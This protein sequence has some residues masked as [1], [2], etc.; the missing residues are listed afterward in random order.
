MG[1]LDRVGRRIAARSGVCHFLRLC[2]YR[3]PVGFANP[4]LTRLMKANLISRVR[5]ICDTYQSGLEDE[6]VIVERFRETCF[7][8]YLRS[9]LIVRQAQER[10]YPLFRQV[11][12]NLAIPDWGSAS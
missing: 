7:P 10:N 6:S 2:A 9:L 1:W 4:L 8:L 12:P 5:A 3:P 11:V